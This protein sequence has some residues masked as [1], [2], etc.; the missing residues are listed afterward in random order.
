MFLS[1]WIILLLGLITL[2]IFGA[3]NLAVREESAS[4]PWGILVPSY[5]FFALT[6]TGSSLVNSIFTV[7]NVKQFKPFI[8]RGV[9]LSFV[10]IIPAVIFIIMDLGRWNHAYNLYLLFNPTSRVGWMGMLY[11]GYV[12]SLLAELVIVIKEDRMPKWATKAIGIV[13]MVITLGVATNLGALFGAIIAKPLL[14][15]Y[16]LPVHFV[17]SGFLAGAAMQILFFSVCSYINKRSITE[18]YKNLFVKAYRPLIIGLILVGWFLTVVNVTP[19]S[20]AST[21]APYTQ[22][23]LA[24]PYSMQFWGFEIFVGGVIPLFLLLNRRTRGSAKWILTSSALVVIGMYFSK[25]DLLIAGQSITPF[26]SEFIAYTPPGMDALLLT[27]GIALCLFCCTV[28][29]M[30]LPLG[31]DERPKWFIFSKEKR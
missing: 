26:G 6:A 5:V 2:G 19:E 16:S 22:L 18:E 1:I 24:G 10:L 27:G 4:I 14:F 7:F 21:E 20:F 23:L 30:L 28:G 13:V 3:Y 11:V 29:Q 17:V 31:A 9:W 15:N 8:K 12:I 25:Y